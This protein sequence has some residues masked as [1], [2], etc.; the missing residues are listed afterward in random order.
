MLGA[1]IGDL[2]GSR[3][4]GQNS[5]STEFD[6]FTD[7]SAFTDDSV[8]TVATA[9]CILNQKGYTK[10]YQEYGKK[11]PNAGY[12]GTFYKWIFSDN[13]KPYNSWGNGS[14]MRVS[15]VAY[16]FN[17]LET[18]LEE[19]QKSAEVTHNHP[20]G[21]K[22]AQAVA[23]A[24]FLARTGKNKAEIK[25]YIQAKF[26]YDLER[27]LDEIR[28]VYRFDVS[29]QGSVPEAIIAFIESADFESAI[30]LSISLGGD[31]DT[32]AAM[33]GS[34]A[35]AFYKEIPEKMISETKKRLPDEFLEII[36]RFIERFYR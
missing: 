20:E 32:I 17:D 7:K 14:A 24:V 3:F 13:P 2:I 10:V 29:C 25:D 18:V 6:L 34:I 9:D 15:P 22:G 16:A 31:S 27:T 8:L 33:A 11:Y 28:P 4:E 35:E 21:I 26:G 19:A 5:K 23:S 1:I 12:G 30:R 36:K